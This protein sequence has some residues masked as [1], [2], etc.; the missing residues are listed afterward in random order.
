MVK[1]LWNIQSFLEYSATLVDDWKVHETH[2]GLDIA[3]S[4]LVKSSSVF[5]F[6]L[7]VNVIAPLH[8]KLT[9]FK[10]ASDWSF[11]PS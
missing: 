1:R 10:G 2:S 8:L 6:W 4:I 11:N 3:Y 5:H 7:M 9:K